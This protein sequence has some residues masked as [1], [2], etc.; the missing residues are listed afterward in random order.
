MSQLS[1]E[2]SDRIWQE[3]AR[4]AV[5]SHSNP[6]FPYITYIHC[7]LLYSIKRPLIDKGMYSIVQDSYANTI[8]K[9]ATITG[10]TDVGI[11]A[12]ADLFY[13]NI[14]N[15]DLK[16]P[17]LHLR[18]DI[19]AELYIASAFD[20]PDNNLR[21]PMEEEVYLFMSASN[22]VADYIQA[23]LP[24]YTPT[25]SAAPVQ[26][27]KPPAPAPVWNTKPHYVAPPK[28]TMDNPPMDEGHALTLLI[29]TISAILGAAAYFIL[30]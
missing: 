5:K 6:C 25:R 3:A 11:N 28:K 13:M 24:S 10:N 1:D 23:T 18:L 16:Q 26:Q 8:R 20:N 17:N 7:L 19:I 14:D 15:L 30:H 12:M 21:F 29:C 22:N 2:I 4:Y 9:V 27:T